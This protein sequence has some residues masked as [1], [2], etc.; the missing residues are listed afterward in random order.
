MIGKIAWAE[1]LFRAVSLSDRSPDPL[2]VIRVL[3]GKTT[4]PIDAFR[5]DRFNATEKKWTSQGWPLKVILTAM[6]NL[7]L[8]YSTKA[9]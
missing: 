2:P 8:R 6:S 5:I 7:D 1:K 4:I 9:G 3:H